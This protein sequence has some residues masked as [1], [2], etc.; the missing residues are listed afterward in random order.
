MEIEIQGQIEIPD[1]EAEIDDP[2][3]VDLL[4]L[5]FTT[6]HPVLSTD[7]RVALSLRLLPA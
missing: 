1:L 6:C 3:V 7:A 4:R 2:F 5:I